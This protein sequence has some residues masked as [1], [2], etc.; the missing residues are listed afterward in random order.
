MMK[1]KIIIVG[2][3]EAFLKV[4]QGVVEL[5]QNQQL[6]SASLSSA[7]TPFSGTLSPVSASQTN[8]ASNV[9]LYQT[10]SIGNNNN[11]NNNKYCLC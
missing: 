11:N 3:K 5:Y 9:Y 2:V 6:K 10:N 1:Y 8:G 7:F 4:A